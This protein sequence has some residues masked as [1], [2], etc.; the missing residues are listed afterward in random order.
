[1]LLKNAERE[2]WNSSTDHLPYQHC[3][4]EFDTFPSLTSDL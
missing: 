1:L 4:A 2:M 3:L